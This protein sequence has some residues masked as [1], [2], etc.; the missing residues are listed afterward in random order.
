MDPFV[1]QLELAWAAGFFDGEGSVYMRDSGNKNKAYLYATVAISQNDT[2]VLER[3]RAAVGLGSITGPVSYKDKTLPMYQLRIGSYPEVVKVKELLWP[4]LSSKKKEQFDHVLSIV[5]QTKKY[6][7]LTL[8]EV[9]AIRSEYKAGDVSMR[10]LAQ[11]YSTTTSRIS[12][13][14]NGKTWINV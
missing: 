9:M 11:R 7:K 4:F 13:I 10:Y 14:V 12:D 6:N 3:F 5:H 1:H 2:E 8:E